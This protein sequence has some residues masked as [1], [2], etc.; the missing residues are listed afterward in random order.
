MTEKQD[1]YYY[2]L[3][4]NQGF[5]ELRGGA[6]KPKPDIINQKQMMDWQQGHEEAIATYYWRRKP[7]IKC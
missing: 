1:N 7:V 5:I 6:S 2:L 4:R 3:G